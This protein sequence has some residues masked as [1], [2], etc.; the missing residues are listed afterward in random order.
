[1]RICWNGDGVAELCELVMTMLAKYIVVATVEVEVEV[2][3]DVVVGQG[4]EDGPPPPKYPPPEPG[5]SQYASSIP[6][7]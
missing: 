7:G 6:T 5:I 1:M 4:P 2:D 3:V